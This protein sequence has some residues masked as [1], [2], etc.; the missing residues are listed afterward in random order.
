M[1]FA[2]QRFTNWCLKSLLFSFVSLGVGM[3]FSSCKPEVSKPDSPDTI[4]QAVAAKIPLFVEKLHAKRQD[5]TIVMLDGSISAD[6]GFATK[7]A[8]AAYRPPI[9]TEFNIPSFIEE[10]WQWAGQQFRRY[11]A[12]KEQQG[13]T[14]AFTETGAAVTKAYD[15]AWD[16]QN[17]PAEVNNFNG[18][19]RI[20][21]G[22]NPAVSFSFP[23]NAKRN[24]FIYRTDYL[25][26]AALRVSVGS[27]GQVEVYDEAT[28]AWKEAEGYV[29]SAKEKDELIPGL[30]YVGVPYGATFLRKS[31]YQK[32]L[33]MRA[34]KP[35]A[36][37]NVSVTSTDGGRLCYWGVSY[38]PLE[39]MFQFINS[40]RGSHNIALL[41]YYEEWNVD[42]WKP[43]LILY[44]CNTINEGADVSSNN[45]VNS[46]ID[47]ANR[48]ETYI[49][50]FLAKPYRPEVFAYILFTAQAHG[51]INEQDV[52]GKA[53][54]ANYPSATV[55][56]FIDE[57]DGRLRK[58]P[59]AS[60]N[61]FYYFWETAKKNAATNKTSIYSQTFGYGGPTGP[62]FVGDFTHL[63]DYGA[64]VGWEYLAPYFDF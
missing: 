6:L 57:L 59:I 45:R 46:P 29:F 11:D 28:S 51:L 39:Y 54:F 35:H 21:T 52:I 30:Y 49:Q 55:F 56:S 32:R 34:L 20:L 41:K 25:S 43:D 36:E 15:A 23:A 61:A 27:T 3:Q 16:W 62:G 33:K 22:S 9:T 40:A 38:S 1:I 26:S 24:D 12:N 18:L 4:K 13:T 37:L 7:R 53:D 8:D 14:K 48:F 10:K 17:T 42:Y 60:A 47:F 5:L 50:Q 63:N 2:S 58:L 44:S 19:T 64:K 31:I